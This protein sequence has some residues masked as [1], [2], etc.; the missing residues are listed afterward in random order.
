VS[1]KPIQS[2]AAQGGLFDYLV[3]PTSLAVSAAP[4]TSHEA[5]KRNVHAAKQR[6]AVLQA[7][8]DSFGGM[9]C[10][11]LVEA[12]G[13]GTNSVGPRLHELVGK[14]FKLN[15]TG[16]VAEAV[17]TERRRLTRAGRYAHVYM[18]RN[19]ND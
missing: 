4:D 1:A 10:D 3:N 7:L 5:A 6:L 17:M 12:L 13:L 8:K 11:E 14:N 18:A 16:Y 2:D 15:A 19:G 9:T